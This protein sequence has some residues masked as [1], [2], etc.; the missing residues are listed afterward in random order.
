[1]FFFSTGLYQSYAL[2][3]GVGGL[4][5]FDFFLKVNFFSF[6]F[7]LLTL[8][9]LIIEFYDYIQFAFDGVTSVSQPSHIFDVLM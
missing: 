7:S 5:F 6:Q 1:M 9:C 4:I 8:S 3:Y 2:D